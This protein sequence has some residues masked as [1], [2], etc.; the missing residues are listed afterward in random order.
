MA[1]LKFAHPGRS[2]SPDGE[3]ARQVLQTVCMALVLAILT[4]AARLIST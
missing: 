2:P 3:G 4:L 1:P